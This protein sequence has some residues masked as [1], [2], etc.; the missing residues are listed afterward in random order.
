MASVSAS[1]RPC[2]TNS[3]VSPSSKGVAGI[4]AG[5]VG[6]EAGP[7]S[8]WLYRELK[9]AGRIGTNNG[10]YYG[11]QCAKKSLPGQRSFACRWGARRFGMGDTAKS[12]YE[13]STGHI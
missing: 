3:T 6:L 11:R 12:S 1:T 4:A 10:N 9:Q 5:A 7:T 8:Q 2:S 13:L